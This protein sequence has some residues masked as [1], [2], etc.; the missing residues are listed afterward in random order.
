MTREAMKINGPPSLTLMMHVSMIKR[1]RM[2]IN[3][4]IEDG[5]H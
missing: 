5:L 1:R 2:R 3:N 4:H